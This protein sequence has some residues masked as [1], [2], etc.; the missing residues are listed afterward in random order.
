MQNFFEF[1]GIPFDFINIS[2]NSLF[3][4]IDFCGWNFTMSSNGVVRFFLSI[5]TNIIYKIT[6]S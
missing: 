6:I 2:V 1:A 3:D 5:K 4:G